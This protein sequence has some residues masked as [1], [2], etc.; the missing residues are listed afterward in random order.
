MNFLIET[1][2][3]KFYPPIILAAILG[4]PPIIKVMLEN[5]EIDLNVEDKENGVNAFWLASWYGR[6]EAMNLL[7]NAGINVLSTNQFKNNALHIAI[8]RGHY[9]IAS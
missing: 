3:G 2:S 5:D 8:K 7:A 9:N 1:E 6:G 4:Y